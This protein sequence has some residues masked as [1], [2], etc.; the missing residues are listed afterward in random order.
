MRFKTG[1][2]LAAVLAA[3]LVAVPVLAD[4]PTPRITTT[5]EGRVDT[6][7]D[8]ATVTLGV[9]TQ[10]A[11]AAE[12]L[13][14]NSAQLA[15][16]IERLKQAGIADRDMQTSGLNLGPQMDYSRD[17][18]PPRVLGYE[19]SNLLTV[20]VRDLALVGGILDQA[21]SDGANTFHGLSFGLADPVAAMDEARLKA[22]AEARRK[23]EMMAGAAGVS[24]GAVI[25][26]TEEGGGNEMRPMYRMAVADAAGVP[27]QGGEVSYTVSVSVT[28]ALAPQ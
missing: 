1:H 14:A 6:A 24:L 22:V 11:T 15:A 21:V 3:Q 20:R 17:G 28:W 18:Q 5:G 9:Q 25:E 27:V 10:G 2:V 26:M 19:V 12:A 4:A 23:A 8:M 7:P 13:A 16:V